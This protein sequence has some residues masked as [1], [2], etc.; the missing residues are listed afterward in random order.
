MRT[1]LSVVALLVAITVA[2]CATAPIMNVTN[3]TVVSA[4]GKT[5]TADQVKAAIVRAGV[6]LGWQVNE[7]GPGLLVAS[8]A[9]RKHTAEIEIP[10][11]ATSYSIR[12]KNS[13]NLNQQGDQIHKNYNG[14]ITNLH[15][16]IT[17]QLSLT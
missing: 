15:R 4:N 3:A 2:G 11:S 10:Y 5:L 17:T 9:L 12:Y 14:W 1:L 6:G 16:G 7:A 8:I 13:T